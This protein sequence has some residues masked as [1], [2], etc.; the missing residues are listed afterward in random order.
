MNAEDI[1]QEVLIETLVAK[2]KASSLNRA[3][4]AKEPYDSLDNMIPV[5]Y[6]MFQVLCESCL[7]TGHDYQRWWDFLRLALNECIYQAEEKS[8]K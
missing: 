6:A 2:I 5:A 7:H 4:E 1:K 8:Y 3:N